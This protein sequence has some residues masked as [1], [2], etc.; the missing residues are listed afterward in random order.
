MLQTF[1]WFHKWVGLL[2]GVQFALWALSGATMAFLDHHAV[3]GDHTRRSVTA[4]LLSAEATVLSLPEIRSRLAGPINAL[5]LRPLAG[6]FVYEVQTANGVRLLSATDGSRVEITEPLAREIA[7]Q[8]YAGTAGIGS[9]ERLA[10]P[11]LESRKHEGPMWRVAFA[12]ADNTTL[13]ISAETGRVLERRNDSW[14]LWDI[15]WMLHIMD[16][17]E[18][19]S[20]NHPLIIL[21]AVAA[22]WLAVSGLFLVYDSF[23]R[24]DFNL[25]LYFRRLRGHGAAVT[26]RT[27]AGATRAL[28]LPEGT[29]YF[30]ALAG[31]G[32]RL[33]SNCGGGGS[34]GLCRVTLGKDAAVSDADRQH[35]S[36]QQLDK[37]ARLAC[38]HVVAAGAVVTVPDQA[39]DSQ[40]HV[41]HVVGV[42]YLSPM[43]KEVRLRMAAGTVPPHHAGQFIQL[44]IPA[45]V[46]DPDLFEVPEQWQADWQGLG[47]P[48]RIN[49]PGGVRRSYSLATYPGEVTDELVLNVR[50]MPPSASGA[51]CG[52]GSSY[53][54]GLRPGDIVRFFGP[55]GSFAA[56]EGNRELV[57]IGGGAGMAPLRAII[58]DELLH[59][60]SGRRISFWYGARAA[61]D[62][63][64]RDEFERLGDAYPN[65]TWTVAL[66]AP[67]KADGWRGPRGM[68]HEVVR[69]QHISRHRDL[70]SCD[71]LIC[72]PPAMLKATLEMLRKAGVPRDRIAYDD[73]GC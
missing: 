48:E 7:G 10:G 28:S 14:R 73:F 24:Q 21:A 22:L 61:R 33:P 2:M 42:R 70:K 16:Y 56:T 59:K 71:F 36:R 66:S 13:Y 52:A 20:F 31:V 60:G 27:D 53:V 32:V 63:L 8:D 34:C 23:S 1:R 15:A 6:R 54:F 62:I 58:R 40:G 45:Y 25:A 50:F 57:L 51:P 5:R 29:S 47:V 67:D 12:D 43:I 3:S 4:P 39:L 69:T 17:S 41:A 35:L 30:D 37:G 72:G 65:F 9:V 55:Y 19:E 49:H 26:L 46:I 11:N 44:A 68:I 38:R 18:R 64:Y